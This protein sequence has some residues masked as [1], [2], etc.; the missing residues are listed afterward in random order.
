[1]DTDDFY[2]Y[3]KACLDTDHRAFIIYYVIYKY[4]EFGEKKYKMARIH[5][6]NMTIS[7]QTFDCF[8]KTMK[9]K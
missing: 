8:N 1:M 2:F 6:Q 7:T 4:H 3:T 5:V 9:I